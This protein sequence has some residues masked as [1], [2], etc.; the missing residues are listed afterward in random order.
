M[1][2]ILIING[3]PNPD[4]FNYA[5][6]AAYAEGLQNA[7]VTTEYINIAALRFNPNLQYGYQKRT[8]LEPDLQE[9]IEKIKKADHLVWFFPMWWYS[10]P[11]IN[12]TGLNKSS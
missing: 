5:L 2:N 10:Y 8:E 12:L 6:S 3:H 4:S 9:A 11:A 7:G 1:K